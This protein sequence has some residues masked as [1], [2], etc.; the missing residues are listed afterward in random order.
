MIIAI[1]IPQSVM[2]YHISM[3]AILIFNIQS[4]ITLT[5]R[6]GLD[7]MKLPLF[8]VWD[9]VMQCQIPSDVMKY[10]SKMSYNLLNVVKVIERHLVRP[11]NWDRAN[12]NRLII[13]YIHALLAS[14][15]S[16]SGS[17]LFRITKHI[18]SKLIPKSR[19]C[20]RDETTY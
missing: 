13:D 6:Y 18:R 2:Q 3:I 20:A 16:N 5:M 1:K 7:L 8:N 4:C 17:L 12:S 14:K 11:L 9:W 19:L 15:S 10:R